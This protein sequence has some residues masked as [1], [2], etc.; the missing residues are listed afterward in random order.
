M[1]FYICG[2]LNPDLARAGSKTEMRE[3]VPKFI[4]A[5]SEM[6]ISAHLGI[7]NVPTRV[8]EMLGW[9]K[10]PSSVDGMPFLLTD[11]SDI[12]HSEGLL[13]K[14]ETSPESEAY[15]SQLESACSRLQAV[16]RRWL[17]S[18]S[19][20]DIV[21]VFSASYEPQYQEYRCAVDEMSEL[22][23]QSIRGRDWHTSFKLV[24]RRS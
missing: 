12:D 11:P 19:L 14:A 4:D 17:E 18:P 1:S 2:S 5:A 10:R 6:R 22:V 21:F 3:A 16:T 15:Q 8:S 7:D 23:Y 20:L 24:V 13:F 9:G